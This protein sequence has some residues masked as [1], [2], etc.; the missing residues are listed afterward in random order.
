MFLPL[1]TGEVKILWV[2]NSMFLVKLWLSE[3]RNFIL[4]INTQLPKHVHIPLLGQFYAMHLEVL[5]E[6]L[7]L[8]SFL[9]L[10]S[11]GFCC[12]QVR[13]CT[14]NILDC[15]LKCFHLH[16]WIKVVTK[17]SLLR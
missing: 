17:P 9:S 7:V 2:G 10:V 15:A 3:E 14:R 4:I 5:K 11:P 8:F 16:C 6:A 13:I 12:R 1:E